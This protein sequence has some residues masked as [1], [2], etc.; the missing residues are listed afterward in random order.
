ADGGEA[1]RRRRPRA[2]GD[3]FLVLE[4]RLPQMGVQVDEARRQHEAAAINDLV[5][6]AD[7]QL[8]TIA[9]VLQNHRRVPSSATA[10]CRLVDSPSVY[11]SAM[12]MATPLVT[13]L[14]MTDC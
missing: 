6:I 4:A 12:R 7:A 9:R 5:G 1:A 14:S 10:G 13:W 2:C 8:L 11:S 3:G